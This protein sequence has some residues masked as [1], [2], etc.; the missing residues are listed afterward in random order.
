MT[1]ESGRGPALPYARRRK[2]RMSRY[3]LRIGTRLASVV[4]PFLCPRLLPVKE[5][6]YSPF[7]IQA[8]PRAY[9]EKHGLPMRFREASK[10]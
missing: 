6:R 4:P 5:R 2:T 3:T 8:G 7:R 1:N 9:A 10:D